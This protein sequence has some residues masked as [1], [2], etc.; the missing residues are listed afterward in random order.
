MEKNI[1]IDKLSVVQ[2]L[3]SNAIPPIGFFLYFRYRNAF[4]N[5][6]KKALI[7]AAVGI[8]IAMIMGYIFNNYILTS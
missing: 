5:K 6:A 7:N 4:P 2:T 1:K 8:P 3:L